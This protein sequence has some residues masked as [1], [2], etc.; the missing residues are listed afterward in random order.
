MHLCKFHFITLQ[1]FESNWSYSI[2]PR[3]LWPSPKGLDAMIAVIYLNWEA[4]V[5]APFLHL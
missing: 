2:C 3:N 1:S 5:S 4:A